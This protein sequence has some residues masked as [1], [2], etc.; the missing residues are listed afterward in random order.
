MYHKSTPV[1][2]NMQK[3]MKKQMIS[4][5]PSKVGFKRHDY[6]IPNWNMYTNI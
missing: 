4:F 2:Y 1:K 6:N 3:K 5:M